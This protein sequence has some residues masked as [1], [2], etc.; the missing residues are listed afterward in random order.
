[1][2]SEKEKHQILDEFN[3][4][5]V[6]FP[7]DRTLQDFLYTQAAETPDNTAVIFKQG[8]MFIKVII[9]GADNIIPQIEPTYTLLLAKAESV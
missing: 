7:R 5:A 8:R 9:D 1:M 3:N 2:L 4:T 6:D